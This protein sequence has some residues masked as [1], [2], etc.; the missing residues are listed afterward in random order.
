MVYFNKKLESKIA[1]I[2]TILDE[3]QKAEWLWRNLMK[4]SALVGKIEA[5]LKA[6]KE[7]KTEAAGI[8]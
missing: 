3:L 7:A 8:Q 5:T 4:Y 2:E 1:R 6:M